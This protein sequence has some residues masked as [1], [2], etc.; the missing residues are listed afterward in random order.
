M[1]DKLPGSDQQEEE[2]VARPG[3]RKLLKLF[4]YR[5]GRGSQLNQLLPFSH[6]GNTPRVSH[7]GKSPDPKNQKA[8]N[9]QFNTRAYPL[10]APLEAKLDD[11]KDAQPSTKTAQPGE[12]TST[13]GSH[14]DNDMWTIAEE[15]LRKD[16]Q[17]CEKLEEYDRILEDYFGSK[18]KPV[19]TMERREQFLGFLSSEIEKLNEADIETR[20]RKCSNKA[21]RFFKSA[22]GCII[23]S[24]NIIATAATPCLPASVACTGVMVLLSV[25]LFPGRVARY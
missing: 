10:A 17:K 8:E 7:R 11:N 2:D 24:K 4:M 9:A 19:R 5:I 6:S 22:F 16:P 12:K 18:L 15:K 13:A 21:K 1:N 25:S 3:R 14:K 20:L 23:A